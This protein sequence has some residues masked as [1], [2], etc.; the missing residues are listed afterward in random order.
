MEMDIFI[1]VLICT[2]TDM[3]TYNYIQMYAHMHTK[4]YI[5]VDKHI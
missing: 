2:Y 4:V 1:H 5:Y 3:Y